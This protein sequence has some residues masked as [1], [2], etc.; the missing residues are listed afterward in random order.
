MRSR[1]VSAKSRSNA[2]R[3][4][5]G[6]MAVSWWTTTSGPACRTAANTASSSSASATTGS[7]PPARM[8]SALLGERVIPTT[9]WPAR[10]IIGTSRRPIVPLAPA[11]KTFIT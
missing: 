9:T 6:G 7:A 1:L 8:V 5:R 2:R 11:T 10:T 3:L 4:T